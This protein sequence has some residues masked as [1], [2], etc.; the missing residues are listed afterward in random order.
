MPSLTSNKTQQFTD[1]YKAKPFPIR[2][3]YEDQYRYPLVPYG[4]GWAVVWPTAKIDQ[5]S[6]SRQKYIPNYQ[7]FMQFRDR[8]NYY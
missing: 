8:Y 4:N 1:V 3:I 6:K 5:L 7:Q 2:I